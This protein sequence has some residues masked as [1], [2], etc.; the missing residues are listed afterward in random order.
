MIKKVNDAYLKYMTLINMGYLS[1][2]IQQFKLR[3]N[4]KNG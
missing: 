4:S 3:G 2:Q 1:S